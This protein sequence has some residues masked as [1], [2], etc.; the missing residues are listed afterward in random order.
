MET[1][2]SEYAHKRSAYAG[3]DQN[4]LHKEGIELKL[5]NFYQI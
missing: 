5:E 2:L 3:E 1:I 4:H